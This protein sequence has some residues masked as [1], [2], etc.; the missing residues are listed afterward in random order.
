MIN[1]ETAEYS[2][3]VKCIEDFGYSNCVEK[4]K[5]LF[6]AIKAIKKLTQSKIKTSDRFRTTGTDSDRKIGA[7][8]LLKDKNDYKT[9]LVQVSKDTHGNGVRCAAGNAR[10]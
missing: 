7:P 4:K 8:S 5:K 1:C 2:K 10:G 9:R 3:L 6:Y